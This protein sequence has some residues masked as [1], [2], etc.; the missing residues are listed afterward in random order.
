MKLRYNCSNYNKKSLNYRTKRFVF[1]ILF[2]DDL[3]FIF[4]TDFHTDFLTDFIYGRYSY[5]LFFH[6][7]DN[8]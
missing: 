5:G 7:T 1:E 2:T 6:Y 3:V 8:I 4:F